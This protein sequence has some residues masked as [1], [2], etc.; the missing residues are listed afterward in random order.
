M[1]ID[2]W[3]ELEEECT[4][5]IYN[6][7]IDNNDLFGDLQDYQ[8]FLSRYRK[9]CH[10]YFD[11]YAY[12]LIPNHF[13]LLIKV[14]GIDSILAAVKYER[15]KR[16][17]ELV[18]GACTLNQFL[19][20]QMRRFFSG[21]SLRFNNKYD[22]SGKLLNERFRRVRAKTEAHINYLLCYIHHNP[23]HHGLRNSYSTWKYSSYNSYLSDQTTNIARKEILDWLGGIEFFILLHKQFKIDFDNHLNID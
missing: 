9:Y 20:D 5:H 13:H 2:Y 21:Q 15:T 1:A 16:A 12:C 3:Q 7:A 23:I 8:D 17:T 10:P 4:Y 6:K 19:E 22:R 18:D 14:K 11:T